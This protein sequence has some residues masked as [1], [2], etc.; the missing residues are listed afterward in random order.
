MVWTHRGTAVSLTEKPSVVTCRDVNETCKH[1]AEMR[2]TQK[3]RL[4]IPFIRGTWNR[5]TCR[6]RKCSK[7][8]QGP[9]GGTPSKRVPRSRS[10]ACWALARRQAPPPSPCRVHLIHTRIYCKPT[11]TSYDNENAGEEIKG[12]GRREGG[13]GEVIVLRA[14]GFCWGK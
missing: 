13:G 3:D 4:M 12:T 11:L 14:A 2:Q 8:Y 1:C 7:G 5:Q 10:C 6:D 9:G